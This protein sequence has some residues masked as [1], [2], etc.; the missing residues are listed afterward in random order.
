MKKI[1]ILCL[2]YLV[3]S[4]SEI[5]QVPDISN[6]YVKTLA[7]TNNAI[8][9]I[10]NLNFTWDAVEDAEA[11]KLQIATPTFNQALQIVADTTLTGLNYFESLQRGQ[12]EW[13]VRGENSG[14]HTPYTTQTFTIE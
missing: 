11:Y 14:Y 6:R 12:Y 2:L 1:I 8:L 9:S 13:R 3:T 5:I 10:S 7:P 4:C